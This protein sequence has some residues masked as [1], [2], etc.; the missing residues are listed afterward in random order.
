MFDGDSFT[1][2]LLN[3]L[4]DDA[5]TSTCLDVSREQPGVRDLE[6]RLTAKLLLD[7]IVLGN[8]FVCHAA[9]LSDEA[10]LTKTHT[11]E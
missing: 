9:C 6:V 10:I 3:S 2:S 5:K 8:T 1:C 4:V 7:L 11:K